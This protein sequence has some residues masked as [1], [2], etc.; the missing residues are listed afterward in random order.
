MSSIG[1][2][3]IELINELN[4]KIDN[5]DAITLLELDEMISTRSVVDHVATSNA[6]TIFYSGES[7]QLI[8]S[9][10]AQNNSEI[11]IIR[12]TEAYD[13][14]SSAEFERVVRYA[15]ASEHPEFDSDQIQDAFDKY[16]YEASSIDIA[17]GEKVLEM[18]NGQKFHANLPQKQRVTHMRL[19]Q[20]PHLI[21]YMLWMNCQHGLRTLRTIKP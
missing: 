15:I 13:F 19:C 1:K 16:F 7:E 10:A 11:R 8:N 14:L 4:I 21:A 5:G 3:N 2:T 20:M 18:A 17:T 6:V 12:R 9:I